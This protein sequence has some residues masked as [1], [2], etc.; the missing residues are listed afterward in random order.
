M[1]QFS[2]RFAF[3]STFRLSNRTPSQSV[4][5]YVNTALNHQSRIDYMLSS[6]ADDI[7]DFAVVDPDINFSDHL[8]PARC[9]QY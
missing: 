9:Y 8:P 6:C 5:T 7:T 2:C 4:P 3:L 1:I